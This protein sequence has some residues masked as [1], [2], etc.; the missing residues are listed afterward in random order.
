MHTHNNV[1]IDIR[2]DG[3]ISLT[4]I[5]LHGWRE[6]GWAVHYENNDKVNGAQ[7]LEWCDQTAP[8]PTEEEI[9][10]V[11]EELSKLAYKAERAAAYPSVE[12]Q[13]DLLYH[14]GYDAW[15]AAIS[16]IKQQYPKPTE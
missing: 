4:S 3:T 9:N 8:C 13:L 16:E 12:D 14:G 1:K 10:A 6:F 2:A 15:K 7:T 5:M 11:R